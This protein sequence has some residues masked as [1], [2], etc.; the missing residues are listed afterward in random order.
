MGSSAACAGAS[1]RAPRTKSGQAHEIRE[2]HYG[3]HGVWAGVRK[4]SP[5]RVLGEAAGVRR[6]S[7]MGRRSVKTSSAARANGG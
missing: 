2:I 5:S 3:L 7:P 4:K 1:V 6:K